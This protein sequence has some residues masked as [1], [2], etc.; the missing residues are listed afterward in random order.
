MAKEPIPTPVTRLYVEGD[1]TAGL[2]VLLDAERAHYLRS[3]LRLKPG[4]AISLFNGSAGE[5]CGEIT[6]LAKS[7]AAV[8]LTK[9]NRA[10][11]AEPDLWLC[12][13]PVKRARIDFIAEKAAE[14]GV[15]RL[16][17]VM[18]RYT[19]MSRVNTDRLAANAMEAAE[20]CERL[21]V[22][23]VAEPVAFDRLLADW[24]SERQLILG[25][26]TGAGPPIAEALSALSADRLAVL[27]GP[28]GGFAP[29]ELDALHGK[30][31]VTPVSLGPRVLRAD[32]AALA[33]LAC[34]QA[35]SGD[36]RHGRPDFR[37]G[38][39]RG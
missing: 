26:E 18:T 34:V 24:D 35:W 36:W 2:S 39:K 13:A 6:S 38:L 9:R 12:F 4:E 31:F 19:Q 1:F 8:T 7:A 23:E 11:A 33:A 3:V 25:D 14:L 5:W 21:T 29:D 15:S 20:Q 17:P 16:V 10:P 37:A 27:V 30:A 28:E 22:P 32:T